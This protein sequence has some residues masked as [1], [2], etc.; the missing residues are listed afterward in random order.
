MPERIMAESQ[1]VRKRVIWPLSITLLIFLSLFLGIFQIYLQ[2]ELARRIDVHIASVN[3]LYQDFLT[4]RSSVMETLIFQIRKNPALKNAMV[5]R[6]RPALLEETAPL[7]RELLAQQNITHFYFHLP[8]TVNFLRVHRPEFFGDQI[9]RITMQQARTTR[10]TAAGIELG[11]LG[12]FTLRV[13]VPWLA[14]GKVIGYIELGEEVEPLL[15]RV[16]SQTDSQMAVLVNKNLLVKES[17][18]AGQQMLGRSIRW[19]RLPDHVITATT[20]ETLRSEIETSIDTAFTSGRERVS[21]TL[22]KQTFRGRYLPL[23]DAGD[24]QVGLILVLHNIS[25]TLHDHRISTVLVTVF[26]LILGGTLF[27]SAFSILGRTNQVLRQA[28]QSLVDE[29]EKTRQTNTRLSREVGER[30]AAEAA[31]KEAHDHL[32]QRVIERTA[33]L[34]QQKKL[35]E[36]LIT[37]IPSYVAWKNLDRAYIGCNTGYARL[38]GT[39][40]TAIAGKHDADLGWSP[41]L[42]RLLM[43]IDRQVLEQNKLVVGRELH[44]KA[45]EDVYY[46]C[47]AVP[48]RNEAGKVFGMVSILQDITEQKTK[49]RLL[50]KTLVEARQASDRI[51]AVMRSVDDALLVVDANDRILLM[52]ESAGDLLRL[53]PEEAIGQK[54][55]SSIPEGQLRDKVKAILGERQGGQEFDFEIV[56]SRQISPVV[57]QARTSVLLDPQRRYEGMIFLA[58]DV[59]RDR[60]MDRLKSDF[61]SVAAHELRTPLATILGFSELLVDDKAPSEEERKEFQRLI[62]EKAE[63]LARL[64]DDLLDISRIESGRSIDLFREEIKAADLFMPTIRQYR[65]RV[66]ERRFTIDLEDQ[67]A[68]LSADPDKIAQV[69]ENL[70]SNAVK[71]SEK[72]QDIAISGRKTEEGYH[73]TVSDAG[74]GMTPE[75]LKH[76]FDKFYR[77]DNA[78]RAIKGTGIGLTIVKHIVEAHRGRT[79]LESKLGQGTKVHIILPT[80]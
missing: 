33:E 45:E 6:D 17:W 8:N 55:I 76:A 1:N 79:W 27:L 62:F 52:N 21:V 58:R 34:D 5:Q 7:F 46:L 69:M 37:N 47:N 14:G 48:L 60:S 9:D 77:G 35:L 74:I 20:A 4:E 51:I 53:L 16:S 43:D 29:I 38:A 59:T 70:L 65:R 24:R 67:Q 64:L 15:E 3:H 63:S 12:T 61:I 49:Q 30:K 26:C 68:V 25:E 71:Y 10:Q 11:P 39:R 66:A 78:D 41:D 44:E 42:R 72:G 54:A 32:E 80:A 56:S 36:N 18:Q 13:V 23:I 19:E 50:E 28:R 22:Q 40:K 57:M 75:Q 2:R 31:L 73:L